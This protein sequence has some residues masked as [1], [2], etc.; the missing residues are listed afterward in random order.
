MARPIRLMISHA[1]WPIGVDASLFYITWFTKGMFG[2]WIL[3]SGGLYARKALQ[4]SIAAKIRMVK[5]ES[6]QR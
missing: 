6:W 5:N 3:G 2:V 1:S 4:C